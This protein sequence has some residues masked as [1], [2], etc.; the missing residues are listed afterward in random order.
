MI[1]P[2]TPWKKSYLSEKYGGWGG[3]GALMEA[4]VSLYQRRPD[5]YIEGIH[6]RRH[7]VMDHKRKEELGDSPIT[8]VHHPGTHR[9]VH[10]LRVHTENTFHL[11]NTFYIYECVICTWYWHSYRICSLDRLCSL[12]V[13]TQHMHLVLAFIIAL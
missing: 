12:C 8:A 13:Y 11:E 4:C 6:L 10:M 1:Y 5:C 3:G 2:Y 7:A 9:M